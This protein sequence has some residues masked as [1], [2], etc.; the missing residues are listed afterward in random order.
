MAAAWGASGPPSPTTP[1]LA[2]ACARTARTSRPHSPTSP[3]FSA[4][5][6]AARR[7]HRRHDLAHVLPLPSAPAPIKG[8][9]GCGSPPSTISPNSLLLPCPLFA[10]IGVSSRRPPR[11]SAVYT[12]AV[13]DASGLPPPPAAPRRQGLPRARA[14]LAGESPEPPRH[15]DPSPPPPSLLIVAVS[16]AS[17]RRRGNHQGPRDLL[18]ILPP[19]PDSA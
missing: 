6:S 8:S 2:R 17:D 10:G 9:T 18:S 5:D 16:V 3:L 4:R 13:V 11:A 14:H 15:R 1:I 12:V 19:S 7:N